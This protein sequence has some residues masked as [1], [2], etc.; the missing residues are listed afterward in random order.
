MTSSPKAAH[1]W[2]RDPNDWYIEPERATV[3]LLRRETFTGWTH[4]SCC[5][6]GNIVRTLIAAG[7][8]ATGSDLVQRVDAPWHMG[9]ADFLDGPMGCFGADNCVMNPPFYRAIGA[10][11]AIRRAL[12]CVPGKVAV[13]VDAR[14]LQG[15]ARAR[16]LWNDY[17]PSRIWTI[18]P[19][20]S[21]PPGT[22]LQAGG[23]AANGS[24]DWVW[25]VWDRA[26]PVAGHAPAFGWIVA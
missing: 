3:Q 1:V 12:E 11:R 13:F 4:D 8:T 9:T 5:G 21:C 25:L 19:R 16:G 14:F 24:S 10:E 15:T 18:L 26:R 17:P 6:Q 2:E 23:K 22:Y 7:V 20:L